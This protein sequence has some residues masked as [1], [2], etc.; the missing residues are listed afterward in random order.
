[1]K[2]KLFMLLFGF[3]LSLSAQ[4]GINTTTPQAILDIVSDTSAVLF[5]RN[6]DPTANIKNPVEG[7]VVFDSKQHVLQF[8]CGLKWNTIQ[9]L[10][11]DTLFNPNTGTVKILGGSGGAVPTFSGY[12]N[13]STFTTLSNGKFTANDV[14]V[15]YYVTYSHPLTYQIDVTRWPYNDPNYWIKDPSKWDDASICVNTSTIYKTQ[16]TGPTTTPTTAEIVSSVSSTTT[17]N[18]IPVSTFKPNIIN[19]Q[20][21]IWRLVLNFEKN[22]NAAV[23]ITGRIS[24]N[25]AS[26]LKTTALPAWGNAATPQYG[27]TTLDFI[28]ISAG[29]PETGYT[30]EIAVDG[31]IQISVQS[32]TRMSLHVD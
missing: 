12:N 5:P 21:H 23:R 17:P 22:Q 14:G 13:L 18:S 28:T 25:Y 26:Y 2:T 7:M 27:S 24:N 15:F 19:G 6:L 16:Y 8:Y 9:F 1:M 30:L 4:I 31:L 3:C 10:A 32:F 20:V 29:T 11:N